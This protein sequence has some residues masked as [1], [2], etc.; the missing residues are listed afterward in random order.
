METNSTDSVLGNQGSQ[1]FASLTSGTPATTP[2]GAPGGQQTGGEVLTARSDAQGSKPSKRADDTQ[3]TSTQD[4][5][6][7]PAEGQQ[8]QQTPAQGAAQTPAAP[9]HAAIIKATADAIV[10]AQAAKT[11]TAQQQTA[12]APDLTPEQFNKKYNV[13]HANENLIA[14][15]LGQDPKKAVASLNT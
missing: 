15:I 1:D 11:P 5:T 2:Q 9:D 12:T 13:T 14:D 3:Q 8:G 4:G 10:A 7:T 6:Q